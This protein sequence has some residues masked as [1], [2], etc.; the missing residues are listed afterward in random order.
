MFKVV[1]NDIYLIR[2]DSAEFEIKLRTRFGK[3]VTL[4][5]DDKLILTIRKNIKSEEP[6]LQKE[7]IKGKIMLT[8]D[9]TN[10][11][12]FGKYIYDVQLTRKDGYVDTIIPPHVFNILEEVTF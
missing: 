12:D 2:G 8:P 7:F 5:E 1:G 9:D 3:P 6:S 4:S 10:R 11:M